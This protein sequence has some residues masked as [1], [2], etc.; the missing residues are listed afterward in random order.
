MTTMKF[1]AILSAF[2]MLAL[3]SLTSCDFER[4]GPYEED[5]RSYGLTNFDRL[6]MGSAF[7]ITV[8]AGSSYSIEARGNRRDL[9]DLDI[10]TS[11][12]T[13]RAKY[14]NNSRNR[15]YDMN[16]TIT[17]PTLRGVDFSGAARSDVSGFQGLRELDIKLSGASRASFDLDADR[18]NIDLSGAS[19]L[20]LEGASGLLIGDLSGASKIEAFDYPVDEAE[21]DL[22]GASTA[23]VKV[24]KRLNVTASG[25]SSVRYRGTPVI[26]SNTSGSSTVRQD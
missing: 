25:A 21:L 20:D 12:G 1:S 10:F 19:D 22:S 26:K 23:R 17:M 4:I 13:L 5:D 24:S 11:N 18:T 9:D 6:D 8:R 15:R 14:R 2:F 7:N 3:V 16:I